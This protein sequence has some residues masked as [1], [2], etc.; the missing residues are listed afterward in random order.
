HNTKSVAKR[1]P[2]G[3]AKARQPRSCA[4][5]KRPIAPRGVKFQACGKRRSRPASIARIAASAACL[6]FDCVG[7]VR[8]SI[9]RSL[10]AGMIGKDKL[11]WDYPKPRRGG[12]Q[13]ATSPQREQG[14]MRRFGSGFSCLFA[15]HGAER[16]CDMALW[17]NQ[18]LQK[19][20]SQS[21]WRRAGVVNLG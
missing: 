18:V 6:V 7:S 2:S 8:E 21:H 5:A 12:G 16:Q 17:Y 13:D 4:P 11:S 1:T 20:D 14:S 9:F 19:A 10:R 15:R 3:T